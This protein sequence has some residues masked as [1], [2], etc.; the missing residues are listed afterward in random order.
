[1]TLN[2]LIFYTLGGYLYEQPGFISQ[3][4]YEA[5]QESPWEIAIDQAGNSD[6]SVKELPF[7][8]KVT[9][10]TFTPI[11]KFLPQKVKPSAANGMDGNQVI[12]E[13]F[14]ALS[15]GFNNNYDANNG[16][17]DYGANYLQTSTVG[18]DT[19]EDSGINQVDPNAGTGVSEQTRPGQGTAEDPNFT[20]TN[21]FVPTSQTQ[22]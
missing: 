3:L 6:N 10:M 22:P 8:I 9:G 13:R 20:P 7:M 19:D 12:D 4:T 5:P 17:S 18:E 1:M 14:I 2:N 11:Q 15:N 21:S 16:V